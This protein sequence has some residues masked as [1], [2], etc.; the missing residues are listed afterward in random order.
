M[1]TAAEYFIPNMKWY[2]NE[3]ANDAQ[4]KKWYKYK[5]QNRFVSKPYRIVLLSYF[6]KWNQAWLFVQE[7][8]IKVRLYFN[9]NFGVVLVL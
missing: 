1:E 9:I 3:Y 6:K 5:K 7:F 8:L 2:L 4:H